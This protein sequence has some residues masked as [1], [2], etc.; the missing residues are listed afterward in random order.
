MHAEGDWCSDR[1]VEGRNRRA[2]CRTGGGGGGGGGIERVQSDIMERG[3]KVLMP[4]AVEK[5][6]R[7][8]VDMPMA[9][10]HMHHVPE[11]HAIWMRHGLVCP[12]LARVR[13]VLALARRVLA[14]VLPSRKLVGCACTTGADTVAQK[15]L[16]TCGQQKRPWYQ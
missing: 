8:D 3:A 1:D 4:L 11:M 2:T 13:L 6:L 16:A 12:V 7:A 9:L 14:L 15:C 5:R 10:A